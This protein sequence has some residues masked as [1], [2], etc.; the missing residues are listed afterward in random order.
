M[1]VDTCA[2]WR[3]VAPACIDVV[4]WCCLLHGCRGGGAAVVV[5]GSPEGHAG[6]C[7]THHRNPRGTINHPSRQ[8]WAGQGIV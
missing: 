5:H 2:V 1:G 6:V 4:W 8:S 7:I 3:S